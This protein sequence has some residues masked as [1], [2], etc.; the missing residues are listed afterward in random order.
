MSVNQNIG[1]QSYLTIVETLR[2]ELLLNKNITSVTVG[3]LTDVDLDKQTIFPLAHIIVNEA[4]FSDT[5]INYDINILLMDIIQEDETENE[6]S[7]YSGDNEMYVLNSMLNV[8]NHITDK[9]FNGSLYDGNTFVDRSTVVAEPF[10]D[11]FENLLA[12]WSFGFQLTTR[13]NIDRCNS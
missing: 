2:D 1:A 8:G 12:G 4:R 11:R 6:P 10:R 9:L 7:I 5:V 13:N 3:D